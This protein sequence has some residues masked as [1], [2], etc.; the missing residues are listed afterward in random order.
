MIFVILVHFTCCLPLCECIQLRWAFCLFLILAISEYAAIV[1]CSYSPAHANISLGQWLRVE[2]PGHRI[3]EPST[4]YYLA[5]QSPI[6]I[7][8]PLSRV[9]DHP[10]LLPHTD[11]LCWLGHPWPSCCACWLLMAPRCLLA[12]ELPLAMG[13]S[14]LV[15]SRARV[16]LYSSLFIELGPRNKN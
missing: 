11:P 16:S 12:G 8:T 13:V 15:Y 6:P 2:L 1:F 14:H 10:L 5:L 4:L 7:C 3:R 9:W